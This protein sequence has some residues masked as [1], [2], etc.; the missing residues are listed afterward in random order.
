MQV[1]LLLIW[2]VSASGG[3]RASATDRLAVLCGAG[4]LE[5]AVDGTGGAGLV[6][7]RD[8]AAGELVL[9]VPQ[10]AVLSVESAVG[11]PQYGHLLAAAEQQV[12]C[13]LCE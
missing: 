9:R 11:N 10:S 2:A 5:L 7:R 3:A 6:A 13:K 8:I 12:L 1:F 4:S